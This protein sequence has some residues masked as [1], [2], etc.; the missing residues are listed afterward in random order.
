MIRRMRLIFLI[1]SFLFLS[2]TTVANPLIDHPLTLS[3][4]VEIALDNHPTTHQSWWNAKRAAASLGNAKKSYYPR[5]DLRSTV[6]H[7][8]DFKFI[9]G[10]DTSYTTVGVDLVFSMLLCDF[11]ERKANV[12]MAKMSLVEA[13]WQYDWAIQ[14]VLIAALENGY[15]TLHAQ[16]LVQASYSSVADAEKML[17]LAKELNQ[18][19]L[20][21]I[22]DVYMAEASLSQMKMD[23]YQQK[24]QL[25]VRK[26]KLSV[27]MGL[28]P[29]TC[30]ELANLTAIDSLPINKCEELIDLA[31]QQRADLLAKHAKLS[32]SFSN[33]DRVRASYGPKV[34]VAGS[35]GANYAFHAKEHGLQ[36][37]IGLNIDYPLFNGFETTYQ[38]RM[39]YAETKAIG[40]ELFQLQL[41]IALEVLTHSRELQGYQEMLPEA[42]KNLENSINAYESTL[43]KYRAGKERIGEVSQAQRQLAAARIRY[44]DIKT[45]WLLSLANLAYATGTLAPC[46]ERS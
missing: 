29:Q 28:P 45:R 39:A 8:R 5:V 25:D 22:S 42:I 38:K 24:A 7:G 6:N 15:A 20:S 44:S 37:Q 11:G 27:S 31:L 34:T 16:E 21:P 17:Y 14:K 32:A 3:E 46:L 36:Y 33:Q 26:A 30:L 18:A 9:N 2:A 10:P 1:I 4:V 12:E 41:D 35:G 19:G 23:L 40:E 43:D 13:N